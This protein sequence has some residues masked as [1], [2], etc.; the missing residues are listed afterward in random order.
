[1]KKFTPFRKVKN[2][3]T[4]IVGRNSLSLDS[5]YAGELTNNSIICYVWEQ[6]GSFKLGLALE[7]VRD[8]RNIEE[9]GIL[10]IDLD[11]ILGKSLE[12]IQDSAILT[13]KLPLFNNSS[14]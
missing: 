8:N 12:L 3:K 4:I 10:G 7:L 2:P 1:M 9:N 6:D 11:L 5:D 13:K 14:I